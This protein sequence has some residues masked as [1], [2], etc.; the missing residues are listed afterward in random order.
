MVEVSYKN[1]FLKLWSLR[2]AGFF[3]GATIGF[4]ILIS[5][6]FVIS[7][8]SESNLSPRGPAWLIVPISFGFAIASYAPL[9]WLSIEKYL[10]GWILKL[11]KST[12]L[13]LAAIA[14][15]A[16]SVGIYVYMFEPYG[17]ITNTERIHLLKV[18]I[19]PIVIYYIGLFIYKKIVRDAD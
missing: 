18:I 8:L 6:L 16:S 11:S 13:F 4:V 1:S 9:L 10:V 15:W 19:F 2:L 5:V 14:I 12:R 3:I 7:A 17:Y